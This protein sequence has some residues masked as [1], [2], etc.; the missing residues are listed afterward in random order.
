[1]VKLWAGTSMAVGGVRD[2]G[3]RAVPAVD[4]GT[5]GLIGTM[6]GRSARGS[7]GVSTGH[8]G[9]GTSKG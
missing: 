6:A 5:G 4:G 8:S 2:S 1:M 9:G 3:P 7:A